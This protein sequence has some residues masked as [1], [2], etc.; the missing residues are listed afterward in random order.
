MITF[1]GYYYDDDGSIQTNTY[2]TSDEGDETKKYGSYIQYLSVQAKLNGEIINDVPSARS[3]SNAQY[4]DFTW[5]IEPTQA[6][7]GHYEIQVE[8]L[9]GGTAKMFE[10][11][12]YLLLQ[13]Q[14]DT[15]V[16]VTTNGKTNKYTT[17]PTMQNVIQ[18][19][20]ST[21]SYLRYSYFTGERED[22]PTLT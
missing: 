14:Y 22:Y 15:E 9:H 18:K 17:D 5:F 2:G 11:D 10:F 8:Y 4:Y 20:T 6:T 7:E 16:S 12:F 21:S 3:Y 13:T 19:T 1:G